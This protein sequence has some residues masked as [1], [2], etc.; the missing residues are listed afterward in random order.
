MQPSRQRPG[1]SLP[2]TYAG[3]IPTT[4]VRALD[5]RHLLDEQQRAFRGRHETPSEVTVRRPAQDR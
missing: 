1:T 4:Q 2:S 5:R 3:T